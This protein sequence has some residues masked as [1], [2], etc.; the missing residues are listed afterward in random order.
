MGKAISGIVVFTHIEHLGYFLHIYN[1]APFRWRCH[2]HQDVGH[3]WDEP[4]TPP[5]PGLYL[6][7]LPCLILPLSPSSLS[8]S[9]LGPIGKLRQSLKAAKSAYLLPSPFHHSGEDS[10][11]WFSAPSPFPAPPPVPFFRPP[12]SRQSKLSSISLPTTAVLLFPQNSRRGSNR[13]L[14]VE[15][16]FTHQ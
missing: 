4:T 14:G 3:R 6:L 7:L 16:P 8:I 13:N 2:K 12:S 15:M 5:L 10:W 9:S 1:S 11:T